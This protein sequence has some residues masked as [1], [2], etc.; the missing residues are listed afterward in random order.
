M[1]EVPKPRQQA[2][3]AMLSLYCLVAKEACFC[4]FFSFFS[5]KFIPSCPLLAVL[6]MP[7]MTSRVSLA[8]GS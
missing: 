4:C 8:R 5:M 2:S 6:F 1:R 7:S 3:F